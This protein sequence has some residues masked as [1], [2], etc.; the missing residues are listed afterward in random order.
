MISP[1]TESLEKFL[2]I[3]VGTCGVGAWASGDH[4]PDV[5]NLGAALPLHSLLTFSHVSSG[6]R[7]CLS[8]RKVHML[9]A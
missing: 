2:G 8:D 6:K 1:E 5:Q 9:L 3:P 7:L 4:G